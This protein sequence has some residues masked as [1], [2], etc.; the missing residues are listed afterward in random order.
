VFKTKTNIPL[1]LPPDN[2]WRNET[3]WVTYENFWAKLGEAIAHV[4]FWP[5][6]NVKII[7][8]NNLPLQGACILAPNHISNFDPVVV[9]M[10]IPRHSF[11]M[12]KVEL[13]QNSFVG[14]YI[15]ETGSFPVYRG[16][17][18]EWA[19]NHAVKV[20]E[21]GQ[22]LCMFPEG[23]RSK[24]AQPQLK[25][26][27]LGTVKLA[28]EYN[29][30]IVPAAI[31]GTHNIGAKN[32]RCPITIQIGEPLDVVKLAGS[33]VQDLHLSR[34]LTTVL[35]ERIAAMLPPENRGIYA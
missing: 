3:T 34:D 17:R 26:G 22:V 35:M 20:L 19:M 11:F 7:G 13:F 23:T 27:K 18:D 28:L 12:T 8:A 2:D 32:F 6:I 5:V 29:V 16:E 1:K 30:P 10:H 9:G 25:K 21:D 15:R 14:W 31:W 24:T 4:L 33:Q